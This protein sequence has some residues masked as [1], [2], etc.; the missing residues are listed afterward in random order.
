MGIDTHELTG[1]DTV[2]CAALLNTNHG[3]VVLIMHK[4]ANYGRGNTTIHSPG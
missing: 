2:T 3:Q 1:L 4:Y